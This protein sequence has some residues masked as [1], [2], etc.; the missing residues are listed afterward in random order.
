[1]WVLDLEAAPPR[2]RGLLSRW[3]LEVRAGLYVASS[4]ARTRELVWQL[5]QRELGG[6]NAVL[7]YDA[8]REPQGFAVETAGANRREVT[9]VDG[10]QLVRFVPREEDQ[11]GWEDDAGESIDLEYLRHG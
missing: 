11:L 7:V 10:L 2:L 8:P 3:A 6:G 1:M 4:G 5:V 9:R